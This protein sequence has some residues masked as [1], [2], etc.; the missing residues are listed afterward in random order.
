MHTKLDTH[1]D[2]LT[3]LD[4]FCA[5]FSSSPAMGPTASRVSA[6]DL[7]DT[8]RRLL[9][10]H[11]HMTET[12]RVFHGAQV[13]LKVLAAH[14]D[15]EA[16]H[17]RIVLTLA[18]SGRVVEAGLVRID[19]RYTSDEVRGRI[20]ERKTPLGDILIQA[21]VLRRIEPRWYFKFN[22]GCPL[23]TDF[24]REVPEAYG[25]M[26]MIHCDGHPAI[27]LLEIVSGG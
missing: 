23:L 20:L 8:F 14:L 22:A 2:P 1:H 18:G 3:A 27:E 24:N 5:G 7:P 21:N 12:L 11:D 13:E 26:G 25:R 10:H 15:G 17:R 4:E 9:V 19:L 6:D 16:Y